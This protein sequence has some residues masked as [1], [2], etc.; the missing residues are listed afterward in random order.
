MVI[1]GVAFMVAGFV[2]LKVESADATLQSGHGKVCYWENGGERGTRCVTGKMEG[3]GY[4]VC[5]WRMEGREVQGVLLG[6]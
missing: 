4:K 1:A 5:Y 2:Q 6:E 3:R